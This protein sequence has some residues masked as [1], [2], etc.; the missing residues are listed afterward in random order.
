MVSVFVLTSVAVFLPIIAALTNVRQ[1]SDIGVI[2][3]MFKMPREQA[4]ESKDLPSAWVMEFEK[5][6]VEEHA[7]QME[8]ISCPRGKTVSVPHSGVVLEHKGYTALWCPNAK[9]GT[10]TIFAVIAKIFGTG[11]DSDLDARSAGKQSSV[12]S[13]VAK[14]K[15]QALCNVH[16][17]FTFQRNPWDRVRSAF[18]DKVNRVVFV[19]NKRNATFSD[20]LFAV[21]RSHPGSMNAHWMP[22]ST[23]CLTAGPEKYTYNKLYKIE[24][25]FEESIVEA[26]HRIHIDPHRTRQALKEVGRQNVGGSDHSIDARLNAY[27]DGTLRDIIQ[28][29]YR[30]DIQVGNYHFD[31]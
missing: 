19:P 4:N 31:K 18:L 14:G 24:E 23:R 10:S 25:H 30:D 2:D 26:L 17:S 15:E 11:T 28:E 3:E 29:I 6:G 5:P 27:K 22:V 20:F 8:H 1:S 9:I 13:L 16:F 12:S 21:G 7:T